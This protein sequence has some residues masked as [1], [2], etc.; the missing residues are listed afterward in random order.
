MYHTVEERSNFTCQLGIKTLL[1]PFHYHAFMHFL[2]PV[3]SADLS[4]Q[5]KRV[6]APN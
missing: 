5:I 6:P 1:T 3:E 4:R 2:A